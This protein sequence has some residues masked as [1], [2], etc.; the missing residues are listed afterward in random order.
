CHRVELYVAMAAFGDRELPQLPAQ[1]LRLEDAA[2]ARHLI[3]VACGL[4]S[5]VLGED[6]VLHQVRQ[7]YASRRAAGQVDPVLDRLFQVALNAGRRAH[8]WFAGSRRSLGDAAL[9]EIERSAGTLVDQPILIVGAGSMGRL[10]AQAAIR[11]GAR[12]ILT[13]RTAERAVALA[14]DVKGQAV[15]YADGTLPPVVGAVVALSGSWPTHPIDAALLVAS[16]APVVDLSS[17]PAVQADLQAQL[18]DRFVSIDDLAWGPQTELPG[19]LRGRLEKLVTESG[20]EYCRWLRARDS[21]PA[22]QAIT[23]AA[24]ARRRSELAWLVRRLPDLSESERELIEHM[25]HRLVAGILHA[26]RSALRLDESGDLGRAAWELFG[27]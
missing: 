18:G 5:A 7:T 14:R 15:A 23:E 21:A 26:P 27:L 17:P 24:E 10:T 12:V 1:G 8:G 3:S 2:A 16:G 13:N 9:D 11:R 4:Q 22:I 6:Q 25:S 19:G 20:G